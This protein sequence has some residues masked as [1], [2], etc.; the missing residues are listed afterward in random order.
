ML[1]R[2]IVGVDTDSLTLLTVAEIDDGTVGQLGSSEAF[3]PLVILDTPVDVNGARNDDNGPLLAT[4]VEMEG[5]FEVFKERRSW[6]SP[7]LID[8]NLSVLGEV[9]DREEPIMPALSPLKG[10]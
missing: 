8:S 9:V 5:I 7:A 10:E 3:T 1:D 2:V 6:S 4:E